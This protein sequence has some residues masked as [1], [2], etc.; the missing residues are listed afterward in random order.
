MKKLLFSLSLLLATSS[1]LMAQQ[2][3]SKGFIEMS[4]ED[5]V[6]ACFTYKNLR[7]YPLIGAKEYQKAHK[8][9]GE[10][11]NLKDALKQKKIKI[12]ETD[13]SSQTNANQ[14]PRQPQQNSRQNRGNINSYDIG[15]A[16]QNTG[17]AQVNKLYIQNT[18][19]DT[20]YIMAGEVVS[21]GKQDRVLAQDMVLPPSD[22]KVDISVFCVEKNRWSY[23]DDKKGNFDTYFS[24]SSNSIRNK[25]TKDRS[26]QGVWEAVKEV[27]QKNSASSSSGTYTALKE[28]KSY[29]KEL[30]SYRSYFQDAFANVTDCIGFVGVTGDKIIGCDIFATQDLFSHQRD[31]L[32]NAYIT[33]AIT[34][35]SKISFTHQEVEKYLKEFLTEKPEEEEQDEEIEK[36]GTQYK[37][38]KKRLHMTTFG[39][40]K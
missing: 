38:K 23:K 24:I 22:K 36:L 28:S 29:Q 31:Q 32:L 3:L 25:A 6:E 30:E 4:K 27:T 34:D 18:S 9:I 16:V 1:L 40:E 5:K 12:T 14:A 21:G 2:I 37:Y 7:I 33:D 10:F 11:T 20:I 26:Q 15:N 13:N 35:G 19:K 8:D 39:K 17:R